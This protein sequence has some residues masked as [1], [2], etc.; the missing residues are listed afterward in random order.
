MKA[1]RK[2]YLP[3]VDSVQ[4][5]S[6]SANAGQLLADDCQQ[7]EDNTIGSSSLRA[8]L[9]LRCERRFRL[10]DVGVDVDEAMSVT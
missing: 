2:T 5:D 7:K 3:Q 4:A 9:G 6:E 8:G 1:P 10:R